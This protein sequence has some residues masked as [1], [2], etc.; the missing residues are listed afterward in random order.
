MSKNENCQSCFNFNFIHQPWSSISQKASTG[1]T[2]HLRF[3]WFWNQPQS[4]WK[5]MLRPSNSSVILLM[6]SYKSQVLFQ[7]F[8][9]KPTEVT[10]SSVVANEVPIATFYWNATTTCLVLSSQSHHVPVNCY[11]ACHPWLSLVSGCLYQLLPVTAIL[12]VKKARKAMEQQW[13]NLLG[14]RPMIFQP[15]EPNLANP[16]ELQPP[17]QSCRTCR[18]A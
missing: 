18:F 10:Q 12:P 6:P 9:K 1:M 7:D 16:R 5:K 2:S 8:G 3:R 17:V 4:T 13:C 11:Q 15:S 14:S